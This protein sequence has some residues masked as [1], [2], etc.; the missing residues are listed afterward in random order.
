M[1]ESGVV[2]TCRLQPAEGGR[3][4]LERMAVERSLRGTGAGAALLGAAEREAA[5]HGAA[6]IVLHAQTRV[7]TFYTA[8]GYEPEGDVFLEE[9]IEHVLMR[10]RLP[11]RGAG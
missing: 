9:D 4:K 8:S 3:F 1:D 6:E 5:R 10:K 7:Q 11:P 2:A